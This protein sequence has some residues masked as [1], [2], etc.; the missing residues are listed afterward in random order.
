VKLYFSPGACSLAPHILLRE[1]EL[2]FELEQVDLNT[3]LTVAGANFLEINPKGQVPVLLLQDGDILTE[4]PAILQYIADMVPMMGLV[5]PSG[6]KERYHAQEWLNFITSELHKNF[7]QLFRPGTPTACKSI[8]TENIASWFSYVDKHLITRKYLMGERFMI[9]DPYLF[10]M[11]S[12]AERVQI[13]LNDWPSLAAFHQRVAERPSVQE[14]RRIESRYAENWIL[15]GNTLAAAVPDVRE[16]VPDVFQQLRAALKDAGPGLPAIKIGIVDGL[17]D[18]THPALRTA[19]IEILEAMIPDGSC[20]PDSHG[21]SVC[22]IIFGHS[23]DICGLAPGC[24]GLVLPIFFGNGPEERPRPA[25]QL[26][27]ARGITF[28]LERDVSI[29]NISAGQKVA[30]AEADEHLDQALRRCAERK[31]LVVAAAGNDSCPCLHLPAGV[32]S[33]LA[34]GA[35]D[36]RGQ[37]L[38]ISN[39]GEPYRKN[40][41]LAPGEAM[42]VAVPGGGA[43]VRK[44]S[45][46]RCGALGDRSAQEHGGT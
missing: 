7:G 19:S 28:A 31:V 12:A 36:V 39:W 17:P 35:A 10:V 33:V 34:V 41:I 45:G 44:P 26:D 23:D 14:A 20:A 9:P 18:L 40:G 27:L 30:A 24:S 11:T 38:E 5:P 8:A 46:S 43:R 21:T 2:P 29:I 15:D 25:S 42:K 22:S 37:P 3:K 16:A 32:S 4:G 1:A 13:K 6:T